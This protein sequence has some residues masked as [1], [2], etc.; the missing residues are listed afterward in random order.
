MIEHLIATGQPDSDL[1]QELAM[2]DQ[3][4]PMSVVIAR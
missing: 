3:R 2:N 1:L 4:D